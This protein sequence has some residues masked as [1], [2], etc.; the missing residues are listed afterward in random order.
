[1]NAGALTRARGR[2]A[3]S[4]RAAL[5][6]ARISRA[7]V[8]IVLL[9]AAG[10]AWAIASSPVDTGPHEVLAPAGVQADHIGRL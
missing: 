7:L 4:P 8:F 1:M 2:D 3:G 5:R 10:A 9:L 6:D